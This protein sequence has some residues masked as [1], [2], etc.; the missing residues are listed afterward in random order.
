MYRLVSGHYPLEARNLAELRDRHRNG[1][2]RPLRDLRPDLSAGFVQLVERATDPEPERRLASAAELERALMAASDSAPSLSAADRPEHRVSAA[3]DRSRMSWFLAAAVVV[4]AIAA[5]VLSVR[6]RTRPEPGNE[7]EASV[8]RTVS[9]P[10]DSVQV[11]APQ[12]PDVSTIESSSRLDAPEPALP[13]PLTASATLLRRRGG[14]PERLLSDAAVAP[15]DHLCMEVEIA[16][17]VHLYVLNEDQEDA[18]FVLFPLPGLDL[19]NPV[20][21]GRHLLP[22]SQAGVSHDWQVTSAGGTETFLVVA[23]RQRLG[24]LEEELARLSAAGSETEHDGDT[25]RGV[26]G[27]A[28][29]S[30]SGT[31]GLDRLVS[32][33]EA[34]R[35]RDGSVWVERFALAN[36]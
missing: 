32:D 33:L 7:P 34:Q 26:G 18:L 30:R 35:Q 12:R 17:V 11:G 19:T 24:W 4:L 5:T 36:P 14:T 27:L 20:P 1:S 28:P 21:A 22:G 31:P 15:G 3:P 6:W 10:E 16:E 8:G 9:V 29:A 25:E 13:Q 2:R 23:S